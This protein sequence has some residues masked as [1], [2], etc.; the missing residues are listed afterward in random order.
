M[1]LRENGQEKREDCLK[2]R[3]LSFGSCRHG[4]KSGQFRH[5]IGPGLDFGADGF[6]LVGQE[7]YL[8]PGKHHIVD[9]AVRIVALDGH[10]IRVVVGI[11]G[12]RSPVCGRDGR[13]A[14]QGG[15]TGGKAGKA[16]EP[17]RPGADRDGVRYR[18]EARDM[19]A[20]R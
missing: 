6:I 17:V 20:G 14:E 1:A 2:N 15:C 4:D 16:V 10:G 8:V 11:V 3:V 7:G 19:D 12:G 5:G 18:S 9:L 13:S